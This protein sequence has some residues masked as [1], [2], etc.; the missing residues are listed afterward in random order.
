MKKLLL[1]SLFLFVAM[2]AFSQITGTV[3]D[4]DTAEPLVGVSVVVKGTSTGTETALD[5]S[6]AIKANPQDVLTFSFIGYLSQDIAIA[7]NK[8][9]NIELQQDI[10]LLSEVVVVGY[11]VQKKSD[12]TGAVASFNTKELEEKPYP[13]IIQ[14]LQGSVAGL[15]ISMSGSDAEGSMS[16]TV[17]RGGN[18]IS[19]SNKPLVILDGIP[20]SG[21]WSEINSNDVESI[22]VLKD[23]SS[24]AI[25]GARG[26]NGVILIQT[27]MGKSDKV[28][29]SYDGYMSF[30][31]A[32]NIPKMMDGE[33]FYQR[34]LEAGGDFS[35]TEL[36]M[37]AEGRS[38]D[39]LS[40]AL[41]N[42]FKHQHNVSFRGKSKSTSY[43]VSG[44]ISDNRG[45]SIGDQFRRISFRANLDQKL[46][47]W[48]KF[49]TSTSFGH[50]DRSG[51]GANFSGAYLMNPLSEPY[52]EDGSL[53]LQ[54]WEDN[55][56][57]GNP[58]S[59]LNEIN[60]DIT[61]RF[62]TNNYFEV[63][64]PV[65]GLSYK[66]NTGYTF[67]SRLYQNYQGRDTYG[68]AKANGILDITNTLDEDWLIENIVTYKREFDK[69]S[70]F[71]TALYSAQNERTIS[72]STTAQDFPNDVMTYYQPDKAST[73]KSTSSY[74]N[75]SHI[76]QMLR[77][78]Y[79]YDSRYL[80]TLTA[81]RDGYSAFGSDRKYGVFPSAALGW[82][83][84][85]EGFMSNVKDVM[86]NLK[87]RI[88]WGRNGNEAISAYSSLPNMRGKNYMTDDGGP[89]FGFYPSK[90]ASPNLGWET[91][92]QTN[93]GVDFA[94]LKNR[95]HGALDMYVSNTTDLLLSR[96]IPSINGTSS[97]LENIGR[98]K[99]NGIEFQISSA[100]IE[101]RNFSWSTD[102]NIVHYNTSIV[103]VGLYGED[104]EPIDDIASE[105]FVGYPVNVNYDYVFDG[106][107]QVG[108]VPENAPFNSQPGYIRYKDIN[109]DGQI[110][111]EDDKTIIGS[112]IPLFTMGLS[113]TF[114]YKNLYLSIFMHGSYGITA[115]NYLM[116]VASISYRQNQLDKE[117]WTESNPIDTYPANVL[118]GSVNPAR[119]YIYQRADFLRIKDVNLTYKFPENLTRGMKIQR[120]EI[121]ANIKNLY[122][123]TNWGGLD[124]EFTGSGTRQRSVPQT[125]QFLFGARFDF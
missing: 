7:N 27:K 91:T 63:T 107:Y 79:G 35:Y 89:A 19:A 26:A 80:L 41:R 94:F 76:S 37:H 124:P 120:L 24:A 60:N 113:N 4:K 108:Q 46:N 74:V 15:N 122:T 45:I 49:G 86:N 39:W 99:G 82:N 29:I 119:M 117:F 28:T 18:S 23:A 11:G 81:R 22:E 50:F 93:L 111:P 69:H 109:G 10:S 70:I 96:T 87:F 105:W 95:I 48:L 65:K 25:Y 121:Y 73:S 118:D 5:G 56:Y 58:L 14:A 85:N 2:P 90:L 36:K 17:I 47:K 66:L 30:D 59:P 98:T 31:R 54:T 101:K 106:I 40:L 32:I 68:G 9:L 110:K 33:T 115:P 16:S 21:N 3:I 114:R 125:R 64:F 100:N 44:N 1:F 88:S 72:N 104:G 13:N 83:I 112:C 78:N 103:D 53:R 92:E 116:S 77:V 34:K 61:R 123:F 67:K 102:F 62:V 84:I 55:N 75:E 42:G 6:F 97:I 43:Y 52:N 51:N 8:H 57:A 12:I 38:T 71:V 20:F